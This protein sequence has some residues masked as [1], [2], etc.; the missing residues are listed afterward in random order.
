MRDVNG[1]KL[2]VLQSCNSKN[3]AKGGISDS[4]SKGLFEI[5]AR[6]LRISFCDQFGLVAIQG[7][8]SIVLLSCTICIQWHTS[9]EAA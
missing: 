3:G 4:G 9:Q 1:A 2:K 5:K 8:I 6:S 7:A